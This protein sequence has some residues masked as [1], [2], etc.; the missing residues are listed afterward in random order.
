MIGVI[1]IE[2]LMDG[3]GGSL[4]LLSLIEARSM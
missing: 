3:T 4:A 2:D 1:V